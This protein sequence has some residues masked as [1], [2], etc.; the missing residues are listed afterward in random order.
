MNNR[1]GPVVRAEC[2]RGR[3]TYSVAAGA[4]CVRWE[5]GLPAIQTTGIPGHTERRYREQALLP[6]L[7]QLLQGD[8]KR[9]GASGFSVSRIMPGK[10][11]AST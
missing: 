8:V 10:G 7:R 6:Q 5:Q 1:I 4:A 2:V 3:N 9:Q 11:L